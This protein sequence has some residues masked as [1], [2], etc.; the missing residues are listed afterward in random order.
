MT[1]G[2]FPLDLL[3]GTRPFRRGTRRHVEMGQMTILTTAAGHH[4]TGAAANV[5]ESR[6]FQG[7][8][9]LEQLKMI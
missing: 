6:N 8:N 2:H 1:L 4:Y 9:Q 7:N 3:L 5:K